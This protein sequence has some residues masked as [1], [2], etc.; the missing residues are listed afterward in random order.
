MKVKK[1]FTTTLSLV[2][3]ASMLFSLSSCGAG[4]KNLSGASSDSK[5]LVIAMTC[6]DI[7]S[8]D[9]QPTGGYEGFRFVGFQLYD[10][11]VRWDC[12]QGEKAS[13]LTPGLAESWE[14]STENP[15][16]W[17][18]NLRRGVKFHDGTDFNADAVI[19]ALDRVINEKSEYY[20]ATCAGSVSSYITQIDKYEKID[21]NTVKITTKEDYNYL[22]YDMSFILIPSPTAVKEKGEDFIN[23]PVGTGP[24]KFVSKTAGQELVLEANEDYWG[25]VAKTKQVILK[26]IADS[27]ARLAALK[28]GEVNWAEVTPPESIESLKADGYQVLLNSYPHVWTYELNCKTGPFADV[29]VRQAMSYAIDRETLCK[30]IIKGCG[31]PLSQFCYSG[32]PWYDSSAEAYDYNP[33]KAKEL[34][35]E[36]GY[37]DGFDTTF[38]VPTSGSGNMW[39]SVMNEF[40]Q[41][42]LAEV[43]INVTIESLD[44]N[45]LITA[46]NTGFEG[47]YADVG[48]MNSSYYTLF[49]NVFK[50][51]FGSEGA[52]NIGGWSN[53]EYDSL[54]QKAQTAASDEERDGYLIEA[55]GIISEELPWMFVCSDMNLR[56]LASNVKGFV[57]PQSWFCDLTSVTVE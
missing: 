46:M 28:S 2:L 31:T 53:E 26:P 41:K 8:T 55:E 57:Q 18:F 16:E 44:W 56:V 22:P 27:S 3:S 7:P 33:E 39:P 25:S 24:Y 6:S 17:T 20:N 47:E 30:D 4:N 29:R 49:P 1:I 50:K 13:E 23:S 40:I 32:S 34:L 9:S 38:L 21:D 5:P 43:G 14:K 52:F 19:F 45:T 37:E 51:Y 12:T 10:G 48:A 54:I 11:L 35:K 15:L 42:N 36:A